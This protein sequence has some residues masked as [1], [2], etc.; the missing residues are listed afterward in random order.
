VTVAS[1]DLLK[2]LNAAWDASGLTDVFQTYWDAADRA[3]YPVLND[4]EGTP[5]QPWP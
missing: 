2:A 5:G 3:E 1:A 4:Q